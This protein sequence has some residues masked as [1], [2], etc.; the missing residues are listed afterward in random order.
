MHAKQQPTVSLKPSIAHWTSGCAPTPQVRGSKPLAD[1][2]GQQTDFFCVTSTSFFCEFATMKQV[3]LNNIWVTPPR[4]FPATDSGVALQEETIVCG[5]LGGP[6]L[7]IAG[8][9]HTNPSSNAS[10]KMTGFTHQGPPDRNIPFRCPTLKNQQP[11]WYPTT[12]PVSS[13]I[14]GPGHCPRWRSTH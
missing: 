9:L 3:V 14:R 2:S 10:P 1:I 11:W 7:I 12:S 5:T 6:V 4:L 13:S 8:P